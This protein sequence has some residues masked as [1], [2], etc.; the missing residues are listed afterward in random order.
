MS[1]DQIEGDINALPPASE[2]LKPFSKEEEEA[3]LAARSKG[4]KK[5]GFEGA[6]S[7]V[8]L[9]SM[10]DMV[11]T[12]LIF[13]IDSYST[14]PMRVQASPDLILSRSTSELSPQDTLQITIT[15]KSVIVGDKLA[16]N[17]KDG[18]IDKSQKRGGENSLYIQPVFDLL[19]EEVSKHKQMAALKREPFEG[20][21]TIVVDRTVPYR[22][23]TE[24]MYTSGQAQLS[25]FKFAGIGE[26]RKE[27]A[28]M[29]TAKGK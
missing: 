10:M 22:L 21:A 4:G 26:S 18:Q 11:T 1:E 12:I 16:V 2:E 8:N 9:N 3:I 23:V 5:A 25:K 13:L 20:L 14:N 24:V 29:A 17:V 27:V 28:A 19:S 15:R 6:A 7:N